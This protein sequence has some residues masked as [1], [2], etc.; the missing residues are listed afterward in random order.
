MFDGRCAGIKFRRIWCKTANWICKTPVFFLAHSSYSI[1]GARMG[2][3][4]NCQELAITTR[5]GITL[6]RDGMSWSS[7]GPKLSVEVFFSFFLKEWRGV[8]GREMRSVVCMGDARLLQCA[9]WKWLVC[10]DRQAV[11]KAAIPMHAAWNWDFQR[12][13]FA[14]WPSA[15]CMQ[16][17]CRDGC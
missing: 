8:C 5:L 7:F 6:G 14:A 3:C 1:V 13:A 4:E 12:R 16:R 10:K 9:M 17:V 11:L 2:C 15:L